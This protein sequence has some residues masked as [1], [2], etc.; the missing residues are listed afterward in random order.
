MLCTKHL[1]TPGMGTPGLPPARAWRFG[2]RK[3]TAGRRLLPEGE[4]GVLGT[5][6]GGDVPFNQP[7]NPGGPAGIRVPHACP[8]ENRCAL[9]VHGGPL[10]MWFPGITSVNTADWRM[11]EPGTRFQAEGAREQRL[12]GGKQR[13]ES[14]GRSHWAGVQAGGGG[15]LGK[16]GFRWP[17]AP[18]VPTLPPACSPCV[19]SSIA[20]DRCERDLRLGKGTVELKGHA[21]GLA[22]PGRKQALELSG[23]IRRLRWHWRECWR[24]QR[25]RGRGEQGGWAGV[26]HAF[27]RPV[28][29]NGHGDTKFSQARL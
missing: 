4:G 18:R 14:R 11:G 29:K 17:Q 13:A 25:G 16:N 23:R 26:S 6:P 28:P 21:A 10:A 20:R 24:P 19:T 12:R 7:G 8:S 27:T 1:L 5:P 22:F 15:P 2:F 3:T 9:S